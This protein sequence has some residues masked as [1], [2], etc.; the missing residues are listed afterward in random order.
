MDTKAL[1]KE[2]KKVKEHF[3]YV[4]SKIQTGKASIL[5]IEEIDV[6]VPSWGQTQKI[7]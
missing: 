6:Y 2:I 3:K 5:S 4:L 1:E 7:Q